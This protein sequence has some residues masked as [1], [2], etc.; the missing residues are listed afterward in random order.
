MFTLPP[1]KT[2]SMKKRKTT[3]DLVG[4]NIL[5][6]DKLATTL[7][8]AAAFFKVGEPQNMEDAD[9][10]CNWLI[11]IYDDSNTVVEVKQYN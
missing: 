4:M 3:E 6:A 9:A 8:Y 1:K 10:S 2:K 5:D 7:G 11:V